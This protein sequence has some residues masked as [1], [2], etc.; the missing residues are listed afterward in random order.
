MLIPRLS[1]NPIS[2]VAQHQVPF[3]NAGGIVYVWIGNKCTTE[4]TVHAEEIGEQ[5]SEEGYSLQVLQQGEE[6]ENFF[7]VAI[8]GQKDICDVSPTRADL[9]FILNVNI[10][11]CTFLN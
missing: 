4:Q 5:V 2:F 10:F 1:L 9:L 6:P 7:W 8:G 11:H 3:D